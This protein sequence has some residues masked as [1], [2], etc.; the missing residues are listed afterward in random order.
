MTGIRNVKFNL[1]PAGLLKSGYSRDLIGL[2]REYE[3]S[4]SYFQFEITETVATRY[5][6]DLYRAVTEFTQA[7]IGLCLDDFGSGYANLNTVLQLPFSEIKLDKSLLSGICDTPKIA[8]FY[9]S[10]VSVLQ[11]MGY[12]I[13]SE[14]VETK[15]E[16]DL[17][18]RWG[19]T[20][21]QG[22]YFSKPLSEAEIL[23]SLHF[24]Q[25]SGVR[26]FQR[27]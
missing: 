12:Q 9:R 18:C 3:L 23:H 7:G 13:V 19:V 11:D 15:Q 26:E 10:I 20:M 16:L 17:V 25:S 8:S 5:S 24:A 2:I 1:S 27:T 4:P 22:Y 21:I 14:G 6:E